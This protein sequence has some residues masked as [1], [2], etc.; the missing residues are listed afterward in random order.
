MC[1]TGK[2]YEIIKSTIFIFSS[3]FENISVRDTWIFALDNI[4]YIAGHGVMQWL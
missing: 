3:A 4:A 1:I 2:F